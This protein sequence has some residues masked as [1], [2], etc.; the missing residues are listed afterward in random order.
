M[1]TRIKYMA[2]VVDTSHMFHLKR[3]MLRAT[4]CQA[5]VHSFEMSVPVGDQI[6]DDIYHKNKSIFVLAF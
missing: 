2:G 4:K 1:S 3:L 5:F 6:I